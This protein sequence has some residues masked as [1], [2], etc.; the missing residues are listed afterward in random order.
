[1]KKKS[2]NES[3]KLKFILKLQQNSDIWQ[4]YCIRQTKIIAE[5]FFCF[6]TQFKSGLNVPNKKK[7]TLIE[8][9]SKSTN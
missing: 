6:M 5:Y 2:I 3:S 1:M 9:V 8:I 4:I 7:N